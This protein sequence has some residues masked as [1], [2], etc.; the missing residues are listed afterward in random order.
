M[1]SRPEVS[2]IR[3]QNA[4]DDD[5]DDDDDDEDDDEYEDDEEEG[6]LSEYAIG[7]KYGP[8]NQFYAL[9]WGL[10]YARSGRASCRV[11]AGLISTNSLRWVQNLD[12]YLQ[13]ISDSS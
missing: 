1:S 7:D 5:D 8:L 3:Q 10:E 4:Y 2:S 6:S 9:G 11:C 13:N 12:G